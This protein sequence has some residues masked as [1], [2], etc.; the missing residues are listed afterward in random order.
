MHRWVN[1]ALLSKGRPRRSASAGSSCRQRALPRSP[2]PP[3]WPAPGAVVIVDDEHRRGGRAGPRAASA[4]ASRSLRVPRGQQPRD[5]EQAAPLAATLR[6]QGGAKALVHL[7]A[8]RRPSGRRRARDAPAARPGAARGPRGGGRRGRRRDPR[9]DAASAARS[10]W[11]GARRPARRR[12]ARSRASSRPSPRSG[13]RCA[14]RPS[15]CRTESAGADGRA[16]ARRADRGGRARRGRLPRRPA[17]PLDAGARA[18]RRPPRHPAA[19]RRRRPARDRRGAGD[20]GARRASLGER[21]RP[22]LVL[23][24]RTPVE[25]ESPETAALTELAELRQALIEQRRQAREALTPALVERDCQRI[26][27]AARCART[28][29]ACARP[30]RASSTWCATSPTRTPSA[31]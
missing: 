5:A 25:P 2:P 6:D 21:H 7:A 15:T 31:R 16:A 22:T 26:L 10:A 27:E 24:G 30:G 18:A 23:V 8:L 28:S 19:R 12:R 20:H 3:R 1:S 13:R 11:T 14:S 29:S 4:A 17:H 9:G